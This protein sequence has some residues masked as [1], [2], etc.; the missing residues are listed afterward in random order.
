MRTIY[1]YPLEL[2]DTQDMELSHGSQ[3]L[4][5]QFQKIDYYADGYKTRYDLCL[6][7]L[8]NENDTAPKQTRT[9]RIIGTGNPI[10][11]SERLRYI[12]TAQNDGF[13]WH[14][15]ESLSVYQD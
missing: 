14:I 6:W 11:E 5:A 8:I 15:F 4:S 13:V 9:V 2:V 10:E 3:I 1:K 12:S 7:V